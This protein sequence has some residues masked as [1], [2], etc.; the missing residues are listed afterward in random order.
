MGVENASVEREES[1][2][3]RVRM[4]F[5]FESGLAA[6]S[7]VLALV[8]V[9]HRTW[10]ESIFGIDP[11]QGSGAAEWLIVLVALAIAVALG[12]AARQEW[13]RQAVAA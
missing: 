10:V 9:I 8:T 5:W 12:L 1:M 7:A 13:R 3:E 4:R 2:S 11:D 6:L